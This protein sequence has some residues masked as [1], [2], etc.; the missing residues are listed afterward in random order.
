MGLEA[1]FAQVLLDLELVSSGTVQRIGHS[2]RVVRARIRGRR[3]ARARNSF[4]SGAGGMRLLRM[5]RGERC[6]LRRGM[7]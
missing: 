4:G 5:R 7:R 1:E 6:W 3:A 2:A